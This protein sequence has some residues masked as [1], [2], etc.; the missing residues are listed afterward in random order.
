MVSIDQQGNA[1]FDVHLKNL[2]QVGVGAFRYPGNIVD[3]FFGA[4]VVVNIEMGCFKSLPVEA[5]I[6]D[7]IA[8]EN[9]HLSINGTLY[10]Q[11]QQSCQNGAG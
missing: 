2:A 3:G 5:V 11:N 9:R 4:C 8:T 1:F 7:L 10:Q 6:L